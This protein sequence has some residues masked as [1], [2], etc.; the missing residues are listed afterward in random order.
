MSNLQILHKRPQFPNMLIPILILSAAFL[1][2]RLIHAILL[3]MF[4]LMSRSTNER[5]SIASL[6]VLSDS[7]KSVTNFISFLASIVVSVASSLM[8]YILTFLLV[9]LVCAIL[10]IVLQ[11]STDVM[12]SITKTYNS[13]LA[14][15]LQIMFVWP[16][17]LFNMAFKAL[18]PLWNAVWWLWKKI[19]LQIL[20][21]TLTNDFGL[22]VNFMESLFNLCQASAFSIIGWISS[23]ICC[24][25]DNGF[26]NTQCMEAGS[27]TID[28][29]TPMTHL[30]FVVAWLVQWMRGWCNIMAGPLDFMSYPFMDIN[31]AKFIHWGGN[32][33]LYSITQLPAITYERCSRFG[34]NIECVPDFGPIFDMATRAL[35]HLGLCLDNWL[36]VLILIIEATIH[37]TPPKCDTIPSL[38]ANVDFRTA[39]FASNAT[40]ITGLTDTVFARTDGTGVQYF[41]MD[42][43]WQTML[44][45]NAFPFTTNINYGV[46]AIT[47][48]NDFEHDINGNDRMDILGCQ[49]FEGI[50]IICGVAM[51]SDQIDAYSRTI[52]VSFQLPSTAAVIGS[53]NSISIY[54]ETLRWPQTRHS[55]SK[56]P[57]SSRVLVKAD[58]AI[59]VKPKCSTDSID[60]V[61]VESF[62]KA[63]CFPYCMALHM[64]G[65]GTQTMILHNA[66]EWNEGVTM[67]NRDCAVFNVQNTSQLISTYAPPLVVMSNNPLLLNVIPTSSDCYY[68]PS[69]YTFTNRTPSYSIHNSIDLES[70][71]FLFSGDLALTALPGQMD[72][73][74]NRLYSIQVQ[75]I[76]GSQM[77][78]FTIIPLNQAIPAT[79]PCLT[80]IDCANIDCNPTCKAAIPYAYNANIV[81]VT[82]DRYVYW[83]TNPTLEPF[84][85][86]SMYCKNKDSTNIL[87]ISATSSY[88]G[89][90]MWR[91]DPYQYCPI[92]PITKKSTCLQQQSSTT[93]LLSA[94]NFSGFNSDLCTQEFDVAA[95]SLEYINEY[96][97]AMVVLRTHIGNVDTRTLREIDKDQATYATIWINPTTMETKE[98]GMWMPEAPSVA[99]E[100]GMLCPSQRRT[101]NLGSMLTESISA[102]VYLVR[103]P[104]FVVTYLPLIIDYRCPALSHGHSILQT[105]GSELFSLDDMFASLFRFNALFWQ[106]F[107]IIANG[108]GPGAP[109][110]FLN[111]AAMVGQTQYVV[112]QSKMI[113]SLLTIGSI[114]P[115]NA[116]TVLQSTVGNMPVAVG[117]AQK[118]SASPLA[119]T[120]LYYTLGSRMIMQF[121]SRKHTLANIFW[122]VIADG[123]ADYDTMVLSRMRQTCAGYAIMAGY[124]T[125]LGLM[126]MQWCNAYVDSTKALYTLASVFF[127]DIP[128]MT[129]VCKNSAGHDFNSN[130]LNNCFYDA[131][132]LQKPLLIA[133]LDTNAQI[134]PVLVNMTKSHFTEAFDDMFANLEGGTRQLGSVIDSF[135]LDKEAGQCNNFADNP[136]VVSLIP[137]PVDYWRVCG[138]TQ[139]CRLSCLTE[140]KAFEQ[141]QTMFVQTE[142]V[143]TQVQSMF[144]NKQDQDMFLPMTVL[145]SLEIANCTIVCGNPDPRDRCF[146]MIGGEN[147]IKIMHYCVPIALGL[148]VRRARD[149]VNIGY[150]QGALQV[151][152]IYTPED[153]DFYA[154]FKALIL[155]KQSIYLCYTECTELWT[156]SDFTD[157][158]ELQSMYIFGHQIVMSVITTSS[159]YFETKVTTWCSTISF[160][161][162]FPQPCTGNLWPRITFAVPI[163]QL[164]QYYQCTK[165][166]FVP[167]TQTGTLELCTR[168]DKMTFECIEVQKTKSFVYDANLGL[169]ARSGKLAA[170]TWQVFS[171]NNQDSHWLQ[172]SKFYVSGVATSSSQN[173]LDTTMEMTLLRQ[174]SLDNCVGCIDLSVQRLCYAA[175]QCQLAR[176]IGTLVHQRRPLCAIGMHLQSLI[177]LQLSAIEGAWLVI[178]E[179][180]VSV[181]T[182]SE[183]L[184]PPKSI[185]WPDQAFYSYVCSAKDIS[186]TGISI[187]VASITNII[188]F[189][190]ND[191]TTNLRQQWTNHA[192]AQYT[193][194]ITAMTNFMNQ[195]MLYSLYALI[196][197]QKTLICNANSVIALV[198]GDKVT[199]GDPSIQTYSSKGVGQ[200]MSQYFAENMQGDGS[201][202]NNIDS[203]MRGVVE[204]IDMV[205][206]QLGLESMVHPIDA[207][208][209]YISGV[210]SGIQDIIQT[211]DSNCNLPNVAVKNT[212]KCACNDDPY[213]VIDKRAAETWQNQAFWCSTTMSMLTSDGSVKYIWNPY[214][215]SQLKGLFNNQL[216]I[217][218]ACVATGSQCTAPSAPIFDQQQVRHWIAAS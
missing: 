72:S 67:L 182:L 56:S 126:L 150:V 54:V 118:V 65:G 109:Q 47:H 196:A 103:M 41:S 122:N 60:L 107:A 143:T 64:K 125:P 96:N 99:T 149:P 59:W 157:A 209:T 164:D 116:L 135:M 152:I 170:D 75:R 202:T 186:A 12:F 171:I 71:P 31:F 153:Y 11:Y 90:R 16:L 208:L 199:V 28:L 77:N 89:I 134:C 179:T 51:Q 87:Q 111:G 46:A 83:I 25:Q 43:D 112:V 101:P 129:C 115:A 93:R 204:K 76:W 131:P 198:A 176:C 177:A 174:C 92:D 169:L 138:K 45:P 110:T 84:Y 184:G 195:V 193:M 206:L 49:C 85:A 1:C 183:G 24:D 120:Q 8:S 78:E 121:L 218:L 100:D 29:M 172:I 216:D 187:A 44:H 63:A 205:A 158:E 27:R 156:L 113:S 34:G 22:V 114:E 70:Q 97:L 17:K 154:S 159:S 19:P 133:M 35:H 197:I 136:Y 173:S 213:K 94:L 155:T 139:R 181:I 119:T 5:K 32:T 10:Y 2:E 148:N 191:P 30:R 68:N 211:I 74:G 86:M 105:C 127:V 161:L 73:Q 53:C 147:D 145:A 98:E 151:E 80:P 217:Y 160:Q 166:M 48:I 61:C 104:L 18:A 207:T 175:L 4:Y 82:T 180:I 178:S 79:Q 168:S 9:F 40:T 33:V 124:F 14:E 192:M 132:D 21:Q 162:S 185:N 188:Q 194:V 117:A 201:G 144:F 13:G 214:S 69:T 95:V 66:L 55:Q 123:I 6:N 7:F 52:E 130:I 140:F 62:K 167:K 200:C 190:V 102:L 212:F 57:T 203:I 128:L 38:L 26:C 42:K 165:V 91:I 50:Q 210:L 23:F 88:G 81:A 58:A 215:L 3:A 141:V 39:M 36:D 37:I 146:A 137:Q 108:F 20:V 163:C 106:T 189:I 15:T 142:K